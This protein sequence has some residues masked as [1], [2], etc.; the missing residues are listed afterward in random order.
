MDD[1]VAFPSLAQKMIPVMR[2]DVVGSYPD[3]QVLTFVSAAEKFTKKPT[4]IKIVE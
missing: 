2:V 1:N 3:D 4:T